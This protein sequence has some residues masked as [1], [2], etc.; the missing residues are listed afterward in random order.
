MQ[1]C[2]LWVLA[3]ESLKTKE[4]TMQLVILKLGRGVLGE[5]S[6]TRALNYRV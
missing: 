2:T 3:N 5:R 6:L 4:K 1:N